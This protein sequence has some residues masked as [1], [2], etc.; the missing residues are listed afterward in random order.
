LLHVVYRCWVKMQHLREVQFKGRLIPNMFHKWMEV[1]PNYFYIRLVL[2]SQRF[3]KFKYRLQVIECL[4]AVP[5]FACLMTSGLCL[6]EG[7]CTFRTFNYWENYW[8][9]F[10][11]NVNR[12]LQWIPRKPKNASTGNLK[13]I[14]VNIW[15]Q[16]NR[17]YVPR[18]FNNL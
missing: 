5:K 4:I 2:N 14:I 10:V 3:F 1:F 15:K 12:N 9:K 6:S 17:L 11:K 8:F 13:F 18:A 16:N 7:I